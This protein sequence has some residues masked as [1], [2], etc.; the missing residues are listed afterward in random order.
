MKDNSVKIH[1]GQDTATAKGI[2]YLNERI[3][4]EKD[5]EIMQIENK[6][7]DGTEETQE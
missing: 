4:Q 5:T 3:T 6:T 2:L 7:S 1:I